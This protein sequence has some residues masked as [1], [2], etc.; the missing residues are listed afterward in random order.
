MLCSCHVWCY[1]TPWTRFTRLL[2]NPSRLGSGKIVSSEGKICFFKNIVL[3]LVAKWFIL[4]PPTSQKY[5]K[6]F[7]HYSLW[8]SS[9]VPGGKTQ[10]N[11]G[12]HLCPGFPGVLAL[13]L[14]LLTLQKFINHSSDFSTPVLASRENSAVGFPLRKVVVLCICLLSLHFRGSGFILDLTSLSDLKGVA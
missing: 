10:K 3:W 9:W 1:A 8:W 5:E 4:R 2:Q 7:N 13:R 6:I 12:N 11:V 14:V